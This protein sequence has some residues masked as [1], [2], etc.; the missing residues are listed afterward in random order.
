MRQVQGFGRVLHDAK[1]Q[2][3]DALRRG[4]GA[5]VA[6]DQQL[7]APE[8][9]LHVGRAG[10]ED[11][12]VVDGDLE[13][14]GLGVELEWVLVSEIR[15]RQGWG[16]TYQRPVD[17]GRLDDLAELEALAD[18]IRRVEDAVFGVELSGSEVRGNTAVELELAFLR[19]PKT[20]ERCQGH[21][22]LGVH[23]ETRLKRVEYIIR[24]PAPRKK[25]RMMRIKIA[26]KE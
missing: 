14:L 1:V 16:A 3:L 7:R 8:A 22:E 26:C 23:L 5:R 20:G 18:D 25:K 17:S 10:G 9:R 12:L 15:M 21:E 6:R 11:G 4:V 2:R 19:C 24:V 13:G